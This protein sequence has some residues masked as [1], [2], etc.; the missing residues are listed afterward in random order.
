MV[1]HGIVK[2][3]EGEVGEAVAL[4]MVQQ[5]A[6]GYHMIGSQGRRYVCYAIAYADYGLFPGL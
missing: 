4:E 5:F 3:L 6:S 2:G 1:L